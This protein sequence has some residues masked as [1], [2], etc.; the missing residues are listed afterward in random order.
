MTLNRIRRLNKIPR[1]VKQRLDHLNVVEDR[2]VCRLLQIPEVQVELAC[3]L[4]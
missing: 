2:L 4:F 3:L 1:Q